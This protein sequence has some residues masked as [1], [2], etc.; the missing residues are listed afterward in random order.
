LTFW[1][2]SL[3]GVVSVAIGIALFTSP[4]WAV[5]LGLAGILTSLLL[6]MPDTLFL[7]VLLS[8]TFILIWTH[9][10]DLSHPPHIRPWLATCILQGK[11]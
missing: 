6:W 1:K 7:W 9:R 4:G 5:M 8:E 10:T 11:D 3:A 2:A